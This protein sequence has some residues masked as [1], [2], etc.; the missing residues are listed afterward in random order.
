[1]GVKV[2]VA[3][4]T[5]TFQLWALEWAWHIRVTNMRCLQGYE[6]QIRNP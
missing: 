4:E 6:I 3:N 2:G 1:M 5:N